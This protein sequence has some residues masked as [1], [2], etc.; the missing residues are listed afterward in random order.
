[1]SWSN[2]T[3][4]KKNEN[5]KAGGKLEVEY[6][7]LRWKTIGSHMAEKYV[8]WYNYSIYS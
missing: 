5:F 8:V 1:M 4:R 7:V 3:S 2:S 6:E